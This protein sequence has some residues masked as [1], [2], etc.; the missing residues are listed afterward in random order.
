MACTAFM[1]AHGRLLWGHG[2]GDSWAIKRPT[3]TTYLVYSSHSITPNEYTSTDA[4]TCDSSSTS[5]GM[6]V[7]VPYVAPT[8]EDPLS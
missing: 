1:P 8:L 2:H 4:L 5:L 7:T 3:V 6:C